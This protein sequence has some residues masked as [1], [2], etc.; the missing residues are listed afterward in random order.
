[1]AVGVEQG[2][3]LVWSRDGRIVEQGWLLVG[4]RDG[5][6]WAA[7]AGTVLWPWASGMPGEWW[8]EAGSILTPVRLILDYHTEFCH[9]CFKEKCSK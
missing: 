2:W 9:L 7:G 3:L 6:W 4:S 5:C 8:E 1:M